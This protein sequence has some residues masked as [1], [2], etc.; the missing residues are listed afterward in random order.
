MDYIVEILLGGLN[1]WDS[2]YFIHIA[3]H[4]YIYQNSLAFFPLFPFLVHLLANTLCFPVQFI[5]NYNNVLLISALLCNV[6]LF[7]LSV[8]ILFRLGRNVLNN[9]DIA[10][11]AC[12]LFCINPANIFMIA[13]YS[14]ILYFFLVVYGL[15]CLE[16]CRK[17][18]AI[19]MFALSSLARSNGLLNFGFILYESMIFLAITLKSFFTGMSV[20]KNNS[21]KNISLSFRIFTF[22][23][24][25]I[26]QVVYVFI[27][28][29]LFLVPFI[30]YQIYYVNELFCEKMQSTLA[31]IPDYLIGY[32]Q[33]K[34]YQI[35]G[36]SIS[37][38]CNYTIPLS[39]SFVQR[40][41]WGVGFL[42]YYEFKQIPNFLLALPVTM[43]S[44]GCV[45]SYYKW[46]KKTCWT[47][48][49]ESHT[50]VLKKDDEEQ[51]CVWNNPR[52]LPYVVHI[53]ML[54]VFGWM[55]IHIQVFCFL[56]LSIIKKKLWYPLGMLKFYD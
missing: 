9:T 35:R 41:H 12:L 17:M 19:A 14:E 4:G 38:W 54:T 44:L 11:K 52:L 36:N 6:T 51:R 10:Y 23:N 34:Q 21:T 28:L 27:A 15:L 45:I 53:L 25:L 20:T 39:Y 3:E 22:F 46:N 29:G 40:S 55:F 5:L 1:R 56:A 8:K 49:I 33:E 13:P 24:I 48:G 16:S 7:V 31:V 32:G 37:P 2:L 47:L 50:V 42:K 43:L 30:L 18:S 26:A